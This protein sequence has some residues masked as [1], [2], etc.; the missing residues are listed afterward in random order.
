MWNFRGGFLFT[1][2][3]SGTYTQILW[4]N[5]A[6]CHGL[7]GEGISTTRLIGGHADHTSPTTTS[8]FP[9][10]RQIGSFPQ[11]D[12]DFK[13]FDKNN[14]IH[15][16]T[17]WESRPNW[18]PPNKPPTKN[19][20]HLIVAT[21]LL[22]LLAFSG[23]FRGNWEPSFCLL[24]GFLLKATPENRR[25]IPPKNGGSLYNVGPLQVITG[26]ITPINGLISG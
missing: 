6:P 12:G 2:G 18:N 3:T 14:A 11:K 20:H 16:S 21:S 13:R 1:P 7:H 23:W 19:T 5:L 17:S 24:E 22:A 10:A 4:W 15:P 9:K 25:L 8:W 26:F